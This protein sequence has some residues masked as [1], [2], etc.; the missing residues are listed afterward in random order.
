MALL[1]RKSPIELDWILVQTMED[2]EAYEYFA[3][4]DYKMRATHTNI[5]RICNVHDIR[6]L[7]MSQHNI[8]FQTNKKAVLSKWKAAGLTDFSKY[9][10]EQW[11]NGKF[12]KWQIWHTPPGFASTANPIESFNGKIKELFTQH[13][14]LS[15]FYF[16][17]LALDQLCPFYSLNNREFFF[18]ASLAK[19]V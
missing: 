18:F 1:K 4:S 16:L 2:T 5:E 6:C 19:P 14:K 12:T 7:H 10:Q 17:T 9:F 13:E 3:Q 11:L 15:V 8:E